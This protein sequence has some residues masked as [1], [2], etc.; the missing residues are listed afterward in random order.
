MAYILGLII[1]GVFFLVLHYFTELNKT[2]KSIVTAVVAG[3]IIFAIGFNAY[4][5]KQNQN[6]VT[7]VTQFK[8]GQNIVCDGK[9]VNN[10]NFT[11]STGTFTFIGRKD[12][13]YYGQMIS[14]STC[15]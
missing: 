1:T 10:T 8:Q 15:K 3:V 2:Q 14:G 13:P 6:M 7:V 5:D 9:D 12:T 11:L 4:S